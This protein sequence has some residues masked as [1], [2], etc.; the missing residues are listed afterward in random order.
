[1]NDFQYNTT[2]KIINYGLAFIA[3]ISLPLNII[4]YFAINDSQCVIIKF[5]PVMLS[6]FVISLYFY[7]NKL[8]LQR[9]TIFFSLLLF[10][11][12]LYTLILGLLDMASLWFILSIIFALFDTKKNTAFI[13]FIVALFFT[14]STGLLMIFKNPYLPIDYGFDNCQ[15]A[16]VSIRIIN[17]L[18]IGFLIF[19]IL[20]IFFHTIELYIQEIVHKNIVLE[21]L[22]A[23]EKN[24]AEQKLN[25]QILKSNIETHKRE[26][27]YK[28]KELASSFSKIMQFNIL[29]DNIKNYILTERYQDAIVNITV[30]QSKNYSIESFILKFN[31]VY[32]NFLV[33]LHNTYP[34]LTETEVKVC[35]LISSGLKSYEIAELLNVSE[36]TIGKYRNRIRKKINLENNADIADHLF[37]KLNYN[38]INN[39]ENLSE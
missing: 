19:K 13:L 3:T 27:E 4:I 30:N 21:Q 28:H 33:K 16:C 1:M 15:F 36:A 9:R 35:V 39:I 17:F 7:R 38:Q 14:I 24:E 2:D 29:L 10:S 32:P 18:I 34:Q 31:E 37:E 26:L 5:L 6:I 11:A 23:T 22:K 12:G 8:S 20:N 25:N